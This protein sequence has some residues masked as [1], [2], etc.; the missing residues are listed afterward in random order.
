MAN[1]LAVGVDVA[2]IS[3]DTCMALAIDFQ[4]PN[5]PAY[6]EQR[7]H[8]REPAPSHGGSAS[9]EGTAAGQCHQKHQGPQPWKP[10]RGFSWDNKIVCYFD[11]PGEQRQRKSASAGD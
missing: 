7:G 5:R 11:A 8:R 9:G 3:S 2:Q 6:L 10:L 1:N 4:R